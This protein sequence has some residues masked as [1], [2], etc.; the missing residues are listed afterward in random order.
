M[1]ILTPTNLWLRCAS[2]IYHL[3][4]PYQHV[5]RNRQ[6][7]L[8]RC[9]QVDH[10]LK[11]RWPFHREITGVGSLK[12]LVHVGGSGVGHVC[13]V[14]AI[15]HKTASFYEITPVIDRWK[16]ILYGEVRNQ[17]GVIIDRSDCERY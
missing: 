3:I 17:F 7:D 16:P 8:F 6:A 5:R 1:L 2:S 15:G 14:R 12:D 13:Y 11:L 9:L 10:K 4:R